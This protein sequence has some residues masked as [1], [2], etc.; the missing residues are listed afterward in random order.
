MNAKKYHSVIR[1]SYG[2]PTQL[3]NLAPCRMTLRPGW[4]GLEDR[5]MRS[6]GNQ[7]LEMSKKVLY[8]LFIF[9]F[10]NTFDSQCF[11]IGLNQFPRNPSIFQSKSSAA[12]VV[13]TQENS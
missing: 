6:F 12:K 4:T 7:G 9:F 5:V 13:N 3:F 10:F 11:T 2:F 8:Q 1:I